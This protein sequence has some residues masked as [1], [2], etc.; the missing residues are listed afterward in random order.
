QAGAYGYFE[1]NEGPLYDY[2]NQA[3]FGDFVTVVGDWDDVIS[4][5]ARN[6][7]EPFVGRFVV[8]GNPTTIQ[9]EYAEIIW[10]AR[11]VPGTNRI[12]LHRRALLIRPDLGQVGAPTAAF[13]N[14][15]DVSVAP[16]GE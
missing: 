11:R 6:P 1:I 15:N 16:N 7:N 8:N 5:T 2:S 13:L 9:S 14:E 12:T 10:W 4:F 3:D